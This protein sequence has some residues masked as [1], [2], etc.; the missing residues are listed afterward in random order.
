MA[1]PTSGAT[2]TSAAAGMVKSRWLCAATE[3]TTTN[4]GHHPH[5]PEATAQA[6]ATAAIRNGMGK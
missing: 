6:M 1:N 3:A 5:D 4:T 2:T